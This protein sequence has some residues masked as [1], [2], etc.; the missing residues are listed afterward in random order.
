MSDSGSSSQS[1]GPQTDASQ[2]GDSAPE[3]AGG[4]EQALLLFSFGPVQPFI[5]A[6]RKTADLWAGSEL[7][8]RLATQALTPVR[9]QVGEEA[10]IF[11]DFSG[12]GEE[13]T[14]APNRFVAIVP[15][16]DAESLA[17][18][19]TSKVRSALQSLVADSLS[20][21]GITEPYPHG[22]GEKQA[23]TF[24]NTYWSVLPL[25][26]DL[27]YG[28]QYRQLEQLLGA[29]KA[30]RNFSG[31]SA[32]GYRC[33]LIPKLSALVP[34][35]ESSPGEVRDYWAGK[36]ERQP[37]G[38]LREG[39]E[40]SAIALAKRTVPDL[41]TEAAPEEEA[42][43]STSSLA[44][45][46]F[47]ARV[48]GALPE[49]DALREAVEEYESAMRPLLRD[50]GA[51]ETPVPK[52]G[53]L[54]RDQGVDLF[55]RVSGEWVF[56]ESL[57]A[58]RLERQGVGV[59][60]EKREAALNAL[61]SLLSAARDAGAG[62]PS[63]YYAL[64]LLDG[65]QMGNW[66]SGEEAPTD[67]VI[68]ASYHQAVSR[69]LSHFAEQEVPRIVETAHLG[70]VVYS[71]GDDVMA[72]ASLRDALPMA[73]AVRAAFSGH[74]SAGETSQEG[75]T[76]QE[77]STGQEGPAEGQSGLV[78]WGRERSFTQDLEARAPTLGFRA[79]ASAGLVFAH[80]MQPLDQ[81][82]EQARAAEGVA[83][84][85]LGRDALACALM[86]RSGERLTAG[87]QWRR[88]GTDLV[89]TLSGF[90]ELLREGTI[91]TGFLHTVQ[92]E[93]TTLSGLE[94][95]SAVR[96]ELR[97]I[98]ARQGGGGAFDQT[99]GELL[100]VAE[101]RGSPSQTASSLPPATSS[102]SPATGPPL[103][104]ATSLL[105]IAQFIGTDGGS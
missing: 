35:P 12:L 13:R 5:A 26:G 34:G 53:R 94:D 1:D 29:R 58:D 104:A 14:A 54:A 3:K 59:P 82:V 52:L 105:E 95:P 73:R 44:A 75:P 42:F 21:V 41:E 19:A 51:V 10:L 22:L 45:S 33:D 70:R 101:S 69:A 11:P 18:D 60:E 47:K 85:E 92:S 67:G 40:L 39:E 89:E 84:D 81:V 9:D 4:T 74:L 72:F 17:Q 57:D 49:N 25:R 38:R 71:G 24:L 79:T 78:D 56:K 15:K 98:F 90:A 100:E 93:A 80:H 64:L 36:A 77:G 28:T 7:L 83:K 103:Q 86:K 6:A 48:L 37:T 43:P 23:S 27:Q 96:A 50:L 20:E 63:R 68:D 88:N 46:G 61:R 30:T 76:G 102:L 65:D 87:G 99:V 66:L 55:H 97:R 16:E 2:A 32:P 31:G 62:S 91:S 8:S